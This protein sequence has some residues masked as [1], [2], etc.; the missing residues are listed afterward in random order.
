M[1]PEESEY[2]F[3]KCS[4]NQNVTTLQVCLKYQTSDLS[5]PSNRN[6]GSNPALRNSEFPITTPHRSVIARTGDLYCSIY[7]WIHP[8]FE[9]SRNR[10][11]HIRY[12]PAPNRRRGQRRGSRRSRTRCFESLKRVPQNSSHKIPRFHWSFFLEQ[13][14][15]IIDLLPNIP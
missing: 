6:A 4:N 3:R 12:V 11:R 5:C 7:E 14:A 13:C 1:Q 2:P 15:C 10:A 9:G 8:L